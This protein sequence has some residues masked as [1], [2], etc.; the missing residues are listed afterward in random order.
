MTWSAYFVQFGNLVFIL[1]LILSKFSEAEQNLWLFLNIIM[2]IAMLADSGFGPTIVRAYSYF[3]AGAKRVP[4]DKKDFEN[5][6]TITNSGPNLERLKDL[7]NTTY[8]IYAIIGIVVFITMSTVGVALSLNLMDQAGNRLDLWIAYLLFVLYCVVT[9]LTTRWSSAISGLDFVAFASRAGTLLGVIKTLIFIVLLL[10]NKGILWLVIYMFLES[11]IRFLYF[12][13]FVLSWFKERS[14]TIGKKHYF[15]PEIFNSIWKTTWQTGLTFIALYIIGFVDALIVGQ[16]KNTSAIN[17]FLITK[18]ILTFIKGFCRAPF[19]ANVQRIYSIGATK[20]FELMKQKSAVYIFYSM[21]LLIGLLAGVAIIGNPVLSLFT[22]TRL[23][24]MSIYIIMSLTIILEIHSSF[25]A[26]IY[27]STNHF[28]F[29]I[30]AGATGLL[31]GVAGIIVSKHYGILGLVLVPFIASL[32]VNNWY[33]V[34][35]SFK[36]TGWK[37][38]SYFR[39][40]FIY[41]FKDIVYRSQ[42]IRKSI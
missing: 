3:R 11:I 41:G 33:P 15:D 10:M 36:L 18:R 6:E 26:D 42:L 13:K 37:L 12:R 5:S 22:E 21:V 29:L 14:V 39:D 31:I 27:V 23:V 2:G 28:P 17:S 25:H 7:L 19:Y 32:F 9:V 24:S 30:P 4:R 40:L 20:D 38:I 1:P 8:R 35:L 34:Y 16:F